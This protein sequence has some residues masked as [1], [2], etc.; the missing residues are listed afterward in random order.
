M[1][2]KERHVAESGSPA[3]HRSCVRRV[4]NCNPVYGFRH[5]KESLGFD[6]T[7][8][9]HD[10]ASYVATRHNRSCSCCGIRSEVLDLSS[11]LGG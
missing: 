11:C 9:K 5:W 4:S 7:E 2:A 3:K 6:I 8:S 1:L 10:R